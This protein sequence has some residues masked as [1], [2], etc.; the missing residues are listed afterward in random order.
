MATDDTDE[1][2]NVAELRTGVVHMEEDKVLEEALA[3][4]VLQVRSGT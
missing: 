1:G 2:A 3:E 4:D